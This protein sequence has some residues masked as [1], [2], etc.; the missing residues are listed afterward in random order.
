MSLLIVNG[1]KCNHCGLCVAE[2][3]LYI[4]EMREPE[5]LPSPIEGGEAMCM[6][7]GHCVAVCPPAALRLETMNPEECIPVR[8]EMLPSSEQVEHFLKSRRSVRVYKEEPVLRETLAKLIDIARY[9]PSG[10]NSQTVQWLVIE[11][12]KEV[13]RLTGLA[14]DW[15]RRTIKEAPRLAEILRLDNVLSTWDSG[16]D[17]L[18][19]GAPHVIMTHTNKDSGIRGDCRIALT[20]LELAAY[21]LGLGACW[22]GF[23]EI[24]AASYPPMIEALE[25]PEG[26]QCFGAVMIG[27][28]EHRLCRIPLRNNPSII[29]R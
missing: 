27:Y 11:D 7:C 13:K 19:R 2:C 8:K 29:W 26:N 18:M 23:F 15:M 21:S 9:A 10:H 12:P 28:P 3:P 24:A 4:I 25:L 6:N 17:I 14:A 22:A 5:A 16:I 1:D 20:Y